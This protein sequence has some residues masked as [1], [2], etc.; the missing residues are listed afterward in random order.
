MPNGAPYNPSVFAC[1]GPAYWWFRL[2]KLLSPWKDQQGLN[3]FIPATRWMRDA[4]ENK[5]TRGTEIKNPSGP[6]TTCALKRFPQPYKQRHCHLTNSWMQFCEGNLVQKKRRGRSESMG[7]K[8]SITVPGATAFLEWKFINNAGL[9]NKKNSPVVSHCTALSKGRAISLK[10]QKKTNYE[11]P[12]FFLLL[13]S[14]VC[15]VWTDNLDLKCSL[16]IFA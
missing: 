12:L 16:P 7:K 11:T 1:R 9:D 5:R 4:G 10:S 2:V 6:G 3:A 15:A 8:R 13:V 14:W